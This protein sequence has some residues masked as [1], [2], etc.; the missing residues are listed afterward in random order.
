MTSLKIMRQKQNLRGEYKERGSKLSPPPAYASLQK[1]PAHA[2]AY[3][4][5][6]NLTYFSAKLGQIFFPG[7]KNLQ[8]FNSY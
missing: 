6:F 4:G 1:N 7:K 5:N 2:I 8:K 3:K